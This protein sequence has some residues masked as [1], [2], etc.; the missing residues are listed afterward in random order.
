MST[1]VKK[2]YS[3]SIENLL[4]VGKDIAELGLDLKQLNEEWSTVLSGSP[5]EVWEPSIKAFHS[6]RFLIR[7]DVSKIA[8]VTTAHLLRFFFHFVTF[9]PD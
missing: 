6:S 5:A 8:W 7:T 1:L 3:N 4:Q 2:K 9:R